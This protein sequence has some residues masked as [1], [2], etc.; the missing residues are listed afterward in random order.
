MCTSLVQ[1][2]HSSALVTQ[3]RSPKP[4]FRV[5]YSDAEFR[6]H[7]VVLMI[8]VGAGGPIASLNLIRQNEPEPKEQI[9]LHEYEKCIP[10]LNHQ[11]SERA[12]SLSQHGSGRR[13]QKLPWLVLLLG[14]RQ[15][16][17]HQEGACC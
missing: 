8:S 14:Q 16:T 3:L 6:Q 2:Q 5:Y 10:H 11:R 4:G 13:P 17:V 7:S 9:L 15:Y 1:G 12:Y